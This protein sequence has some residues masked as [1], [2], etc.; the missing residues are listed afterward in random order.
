MYPKLIDN[1][2]QNL[3]DIL[4][5]IVSS[6]K[7]EH[8]SIATGYWDLPGMVDI[9]DD[10]ASFKSIRLLIGQ[11][12]LPH[13]LQQAFSLDAEDPEA[14]FPDKNFTYDLE[15]LGGEAGKEASQLREVAKKLAALLKS[16]ILEV[17]V[18]RHPRLHAKAYIFGDVDSACA[19]GIIGSSNFTKAG[20]T[21]N[22]ELNYLEEDHKQV[23]YQPI[24]DTQDHGHLS[25]FNEL[26][27]DPEAV[28]WTGEFTEIIE[29]SP[30]GDM[31]YGPYD[32]YIKTLMEVFPTSFC[33]CRS[34]QGT[35]AT[36]STPSR[37]ET[38]AFF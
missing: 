1:S 37:T 27:D 9:I 24:N 14:L 17:K 2:R 19:V 32:V 6:G 20:L 11:E 8:L 35:R 10:L 31:T 22:A 38:P 7:H 16:G 36:S 28:E 13:R 12:P 26:W 30:V 4:S 21:S 15:R 25:W 23:L 33:R 3:K 5:E 18:F 34:C 29:K